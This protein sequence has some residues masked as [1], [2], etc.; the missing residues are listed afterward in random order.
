VSGSG[1][2]ITGC[3][4]LLSFDVMRWPTAE[5][6]DGRSKGACGV[7]L[8]TEEYVGSGMV[9]WIASWQC[10]DHNGT[11]KVGLY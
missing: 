7:V 11:V 8:V 4:C 9:S 1:K 3:V 5:C 2:T 10:T 6:D